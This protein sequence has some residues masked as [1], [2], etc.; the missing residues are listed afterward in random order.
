MSWFSRTMSDDAE[1][2]KRCIT[3]ENFVLVDRYRYDI[4][5]F[6][7]K[8]RK[9]DCYVVVERRE[10]YTSDTTSNDMYYNTYVFK[11]ERDKITRNSF[12]NLKEVKI[13]ESE[14]FKLFKISGKVYEET[15][16]D[17]RRGKSEC[18]SW[19]EDYL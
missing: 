18:N 13:K 3:K 6:I 10:C 8:T 14:S 17:F 19:L 9:Q 12:R 2:I 11:A 1:K 7:F 5:G 4:K 16:K 15:K